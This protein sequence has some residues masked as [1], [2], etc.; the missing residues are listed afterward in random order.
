MTTAGPTTGPGL[1]G[2]ATDDA[3]A[4]A[5]AAVREDVL[6][7]R[8]RPGAPL[9]QVR[10]AQRFGISRTPLRE[11]L[12][13][14]VG[15]GLVVGD[16]NRR[17][18][19]SELSLDDL[20]QIYA[21]RLALEPVALRAAVPLLT[22]EGRGALTADLDGMEAAA[23]ADDLEAFRARH[24]AFHVGLLAGSGQRIE[25]VLED[26]W[27]HSERYRRS[28]LHVD[29][30]TGH[31]ASPERL[32]ISHR[33]HREI[34]DAA[35]AGDVEGCIA[36]SEAHLHRTLDSVLRESALAPR[37]RLTPPAPPAPSA[38]SAQKEGR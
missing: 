33:E 15:E 36:R 37:S 7:G 32:A 29:E 24:R 1:T 23:T 16:F 13:R 3:V 26:L 6:S 12:R 19:V 20:D 2:T 5:Y 25:R 9:S 18:R 31:G 30:L 34:L 14:L 22:D 8:L 35:L 10:L 4:A 21:M 17:M 38:P 11:A 28:Y 27:D